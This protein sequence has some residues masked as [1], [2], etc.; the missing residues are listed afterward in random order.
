MRLKISSTHDVTDRLCYLRFNSDNS[1]CYPNNKELNI[2]EKIGK[3]L[4]S[5]PI[6]LRQCQHSQL[7][8]DGG[9]LKFIGSEV[10]L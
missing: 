10:D 2:D 5:S 8:G 7:L 6:I 1:V 3:V 9:W 4:I